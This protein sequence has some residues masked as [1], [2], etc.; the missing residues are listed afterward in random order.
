MHKTLHRD[1][2][3][4][5][6]QWAVTEFGIQA[7][8]HRLNKKFDIETFRIWEDGLAQPLEKETWFDSA[9]F[10][11]ALQVARQRLPKVSQAIVPPGLEREK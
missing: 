2:F 6:R 1:I 10:A 7:V 8:D 4:L 3:W 11:E 9:D 5:G